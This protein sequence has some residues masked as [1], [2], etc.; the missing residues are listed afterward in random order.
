MRAS[1]LN[2]LTSTLCFFRALGRFSSHALPVL[3]LLPMYYRCIL[4]RRLFFHPPSRV[5]VYTITAVRAGKSEE[6]RL[7]I[8]F[9][10]MIVRLVNVH[11][12]TGMADRF[13]CKEREFFRF[14]VFLVL[15]CALAYATVEWRDRERGRRTKN[16]KL[17][18]FHFHEISLF[19]GANIRRGECILR[20]FLTWNSWPEKTTRD[21]LSIID[22]EKTSLFVTVFLRVFL[23][24]LEK[25]SS[26]RALSFS[27]SFISH[28]HAVLI[29]RLILTIMAST[30]C[31]SS[32]ERAQTSV[33]VV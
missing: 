24:F 22:H 20:F 13:P 28:T 16:K 27:L 6:E 15:S 21:L 11:F 30:T 25:E 18:F 5:C 31:G 14:F 10:R 29:A 1:F 19:G 8:I 23:H 4:A 2:R 12:Q 26:F 32:L 3:L 9:K 7:K 17:P 33:C